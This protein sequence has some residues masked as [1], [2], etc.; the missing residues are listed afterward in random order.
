MLLAVGPELDGAVKGSGRDGAAPTGAYAADPVDRQGLPGPDGHGAGDRLDRQDVARSP[1]LG[2]S[3]YPQ[4]LALADSEPERP[5][6]TTQ[7]LAGGVVDEAPRRRPQLLAEPAS[8]IAVGDEADVV[9]VGLLRDE[10]AAL[11]RLHPHR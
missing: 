9:A 5:L 10:Q 6:V 3:G 4:P 8:R 2:R 1:V 11:G 7:D